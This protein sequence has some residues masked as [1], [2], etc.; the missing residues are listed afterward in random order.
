MILT[1]P[2]LDFFPRASRVSDEML[3]KRSR[4]LQRF[5]AWASDHAFTP[6]ALADAMRRVIG[7]ASQRLISF[8]MPFLLLFAIGHQASG[9]HYG[10]FFL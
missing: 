4:D 7:V 6:Q 3:V 8:L 1:E 2:N 5:I 10:K 9:A